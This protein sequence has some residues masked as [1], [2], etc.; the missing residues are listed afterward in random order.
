MSQ[1]IVAAA[2]GNPLFVQELAAMLEE[3]SDE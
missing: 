2:D 1:R 3:S